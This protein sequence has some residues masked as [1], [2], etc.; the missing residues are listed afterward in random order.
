MDFARTLI[1][2]TGLGWFSFNE[3]MLPDPAAVLRPV[4]TSYINEALN[5][6]EIMSG[7]GPKS[8]G[9]LRDQMLFLCRMNPN[10]VPISD[11]GDMMV[12]GTDWPLVGQ[13][14]VA[15]IFHDGA[16]SPIG[17]AKLVNVD[18]RGFNNA[19]SVNIIYIAPSHRKASNA[20]AF[21]ELL[22]NNGVTL[23]SDTDQT[24]AGK[25]IWNKLSKHYPM[26]IYNP[27]KREATRTREISLAYGTNDT[28]I[29]TKG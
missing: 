24:P 1:A 11:V 12:L 6:V 10:P 7:F 27:A 13:D 26:Y 14:D 3:I 28:L 17:Y 4:Q 9:W 5:E 15:F 8:E 19:Y 29:C 22:L 18:V 2:K 25:S 20:L 21:Y 16:A 23:R